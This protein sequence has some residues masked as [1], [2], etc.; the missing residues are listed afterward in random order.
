MEAPATHSGIYFYDYKN[1]TYNLNI[2]EKWFETILEIKK[3]GG[4]FPGETTLKP[5]Y[6][7]VQFAEGNIGMMFAS[8]WEPAIF[9]HQYTVKCDWGVAMPPAIDKSSMAKGAVMMVP[10]SCY[11]INDKSTN[12][13]S[14]I[15]TVWKYL[16]SEDFLSTLY[17]NGSE[18]PIFGNII[19]DYE[20]D[21]HIINFYKFLPSDIDS[22]YPNTPKGFD[23]WSR[24]KAYLSIFKDNTPTSEALLEGSKKLIFS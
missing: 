14:D 12:S 19:S 23:E 16:Y 6:A 13:L 24:M 7:R 8:S 18:V 2:Y 9:T 10:G 11:A 22:A 1:D 4:L 5:D 20:Y 21:P 3:H 17:K 15:L